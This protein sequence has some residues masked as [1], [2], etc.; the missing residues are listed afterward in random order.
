MSVYPATAGIIGGLLILLFYPLNNRM[1][2]EIEK[3][4]TARRSDADDRS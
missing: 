1:M 3:D 2:V 4:L